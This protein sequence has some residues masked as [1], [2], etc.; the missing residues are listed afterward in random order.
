MKKI[1]IIM[2]L[3][4]VFIS[5]NAQLSFDKP[6]PNFNPNFQLNGFLHPDKI[7]MNHSMSFMSGV[8]SSGDGFYQS[9]Y[10]NHLKFSL[11]DNLKLNVDLSV[12]NLGSMSHNNNWRFQSNNDNHN[13]VV[14]AFSLE[15]KPT[16]NTT[17]YFQ[18]QQ[19]RGYQSP[20]QSHNNRYNEWWK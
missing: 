20:Y 6:S 3:T 12:V 5:L 2:I 16:D 10:T 17:F 15:F 1:I 8:S 7:K 19:I 13:M 18:Y 14:P 9:S 4:Q 11:R